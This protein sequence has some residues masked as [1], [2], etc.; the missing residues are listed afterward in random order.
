MIYKFFERVTEWIFAIFILLIL[1]GG[2]IYV[3]YGVLS[4]GLG[5]LN[6]IGVATL[7][8]PL[9]IA[10]VWWA[11]GI[12]VLAFV[13]LDKHSKRRHEKWFA[14]LTDAQKAA[15]HSLKKREINWNASQALAIRKEK[16]RTGAETRLF[17]SRQVHLHLSELI[18]NKRKK[19]KDLGYGKLDATAW[20]LEKQ[21]FIREHIK[22]NPGLSKLSM[23]QLSQLIEE[24]IA[25]RTVP[26][27]SLRAINSGV[28]FEEQCAEILRR[29]GWNVRK[30]KAS[31]DHGADLLADKGGLHVAIQCKC[32]T[33]TVGNA[34]VQEIYAAKTYY[35]CQHAVV[36]TNSSY[37]SGARNL[38][39]ASRVLL[40]NVNDLIVL[41]STLKDAF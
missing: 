38:A 26:V 17:Y 3:T 23:A 20:E 36:V 24:E 31:G 37:T 41:D 8:K 15:Y 34:A 39:K 32:Y 21:H 5:K 2:I 25:T 11:I 33:G 9:G 29:M 12:A 22:H 18:E 7:G 30:T 35:G 16:E 19:T 6:Q 4:W 27:D 10:P 40:L 13:L 14:S 28:A 1:G